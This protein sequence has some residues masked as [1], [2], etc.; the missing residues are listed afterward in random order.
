M[1]STPKPLAMIQAKATNRFLELPPSRND[2]IMPEISRR[3]SLSSSNS[4]IEVARGAGR[5]SMLNISN[6]IDMMVMIETPS[7]SLR[8]NVSKFL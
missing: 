3:S 2:F 4:S 7:K 1:T 8:N 5:D 6:D